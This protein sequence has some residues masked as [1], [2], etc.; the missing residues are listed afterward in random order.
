MENRITVLSNPIFEEAL[1]LQKM[2]LSVIPTLSNKKPLR[3]WRDFQ[4]NAADEQQICDWFDK[5][6][7]LGVAIV[8]GPVSGHLV[9]R[10]F[11]V[12]AAYLKWKEDFPHLAATL[13][14]VR[15]NKGFHV[16]ARILDCPTRVFSDGELRGHRNYVVAPPSLHPEG[17]RYLWISPLNCLEDVPSLILEDSGFY[18]QWS[19]ASRSKPSDN[20][21]IARIATDR[22]RID[23]G[24][25]VVRGHGSPSGKTGPAN[26]KG[27]EQLKLDVT[28]SDPGSE[29]AMPHSVIPDGGTTPTQIDS[30]RSVLSVDDAVRLIRGTL[31]S[32][33]G[34][35]RHQLF[36]LARDIRSNPHLVNVPVQVFK[37]LLRE[38]HSKAL[39]FIHTKP[40][41][42]TWADFVEA[43]GNVDLKRCG[44]PVKDC[45]K[46]V[47]TQGP[48]PEATS[49]DHHL[50][51]NLIGL[52]ACLSSQ[53]PDRVFFLSGRKAAGALGAADH[54][55]IATFLKMLCADGVL[56]IVE[57]GGPHNNRA[58]RYRYCAKPI[59]QKQ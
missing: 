18:R 57:E 40:F 41:E 59:D 16:Y 30:V 7:D 12:E 34:T 26:R 19:E 37:P 20:C 52:C 2:G 22:D 5:R 49:Y 48:P 1:R 50:V 31:P 38:W 3:H 46:R 27:K 6:D 11:D 17:M 24:V 35:R 36:R 8:L 21:R 55:P 28:S 13:P 53:S 58:T 23:S 47:M 56:E 10:D 15:T 42:E 45:M 9:A 43:D 33:F 32:G 25:S 44:D 4:T 14:T 54:K 51:R 39:P 29:L